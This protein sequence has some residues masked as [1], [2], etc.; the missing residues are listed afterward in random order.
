MSPKLTVQPELPAMPEAAAILDQYPNAP[1]PQ[2]A[3]LTPL[4]GTYWN[5]FSISSTKLPYPYELST[6]KMFWLSAV[7]DDIP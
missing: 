5:T 2:K 1:A 3:L 4:V 7:L 6:V